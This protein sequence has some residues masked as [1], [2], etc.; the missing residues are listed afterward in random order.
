[1]SKVTRGRKTEGGLI[2]K[3]TRGKRFI[4]SSNG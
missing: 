3:M 1:M 2:A 4:M